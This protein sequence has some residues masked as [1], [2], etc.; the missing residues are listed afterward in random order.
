MSY[1]RWSSNDHQCDL[2]IYEDARDLW[3][4]HVASSRVQYIEPLPPPVNAVTE[5][6]RW[7][8]RYATVSR[9]FDRSPHVPIGLPYDGQSFE[10]DS[11][12]AC[13]DRVAMLRALGYQCPDHVEGALRE[14]Q[15]ALEAQG[16]PHVR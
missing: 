3:V 1:C 14:E 16:V 11:P 5:W 8:D 6:Q 10:D 9:L 2:Y 7:M 13:A 12:G 15:A 4:T